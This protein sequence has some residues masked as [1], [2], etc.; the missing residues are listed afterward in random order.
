MPVE[1]LLKRPA[2]IIVSADKARHSKVPLPRDLYGPERANSQGVEFGHQASLEALLAEIEKSAQ[3]SYKAEPLID[4]K[5]A[6][7]H[8]ASASSAP[9]TARPSRAR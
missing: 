1:A 3:Q 4:G 6:L 7:R 2:D 9:S 5:A 8:V